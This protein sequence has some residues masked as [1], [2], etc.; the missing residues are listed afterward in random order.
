MTKGQKFWVVLSQKYLMLWQKVL[1]VMLWQH[2]WVMLWQD[3]GWCCGKEILW[4]CEAHYIAPTGQDFLF[5]WDNRIQFNFCF[6]KRFSNKVSFQR[7]FRWTILFTN[8]TRK[9]LINFHFVVLG[10]SFKIWNKW[11]LLKYEFFKVYLNLIGVYTLF[12]WLNDDSNSKFKPISCWMT[13][14]KQIDLS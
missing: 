13:N 1:W 2:L 14:K 5:Q 9:F 11:S 4:G 7:I 12:N 8:T 10:S 6:T 3:I